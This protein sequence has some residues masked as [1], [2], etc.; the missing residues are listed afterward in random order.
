MTEKYISIFEF[1]KKHET[2]PSNVYRWI[3]E[4]RI[5]EEDVT[6]EKVT[7]E[8]KRIRADAKLEKSTYK[9]TD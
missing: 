7:K 2:S 5:K 1:A 3:R 9:F 4:R 8:R 6:V